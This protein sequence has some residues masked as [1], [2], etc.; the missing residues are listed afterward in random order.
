[1]LAFYPV[2]RLTTAM[3]TTSASIMLAQVLSA[4]M[5]AALMSLHGAA[6]LQ[7][8]QW[9]ALA[10]GGAT[11]AI[12]LTLKFV[13]PT[14]PAHIKSLSTEEVAWVQSRVPKYAIRELAP[15]VLLPPSTTHTGH[16]TCRR[17]NPVLPGLFGQHSCMCK[18]RTLHA[19]V[20]WMCQMHE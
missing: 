14:S 19:C 7:G 13:L 11:V 12:G 9:I 16:T 15:T 18:I 20:A 4:P 3:A 10:E 6:G 17:R 5:A 1:M 8:W 2:G